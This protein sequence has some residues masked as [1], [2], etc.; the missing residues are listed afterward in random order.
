MVKGKPW[1]KESTNLLRKYYNK[2]RIE[3]MQE[4]LHEQEGF[5]RSKDSIYTKAHKIKV[6]K[7]WGTS[8]PKQTNP[9]KRRNNP[10][11]NIIKRQVANG[12]LKVEE[13]GSEGK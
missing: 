8:K 4:I 11:E 6:S 13:V 3:R 7:A 5:Q 9:E 10:L 2:V 1:K 12:F